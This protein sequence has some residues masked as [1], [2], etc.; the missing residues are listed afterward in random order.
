[1]TTPLL[2]VRDLHKHF[3]VGT[4]GLL[5]RPAQMLRAVDGVSFDVHRGE[6]L[7]L[8]GESG[9]GKSTCARTVV[10]LYEPT[11]GSV[12]YEGAEIS[13]L[14]R[15]DRAPYRRK[16]QMIF[17][18]PYA[19][20]DPRQTVASILAEPLKIHSPGEAARAPPAR[21][22]AAGR[23]GAEP[24]AR[25]P[26]PPRVLRRP[27]PADRR[28]PGARHG[29]RP[30]H[31]RRAR[32]RARRVDPGP[33]GQPARGAPGALRALLSLHRPRPRGGAAHLRPRR[34]DVP[35]QDRRDRGARRAL[36]EPAAPLHPRAPLRRAAPRSED[37]THA[38][39]HRARG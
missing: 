21:D 24:A 33:G 36:R 1:M 13:G 35:R 16:I 18:D 23:R 2:Q 30:D 22:A 14:S 28:R 15:K 17:Q 31:L 27:A 32:Q 25:P 3:A 11:A 37:R 26:L 34:R 20:L 39:A 10:G 19:S 8:V 29:A 5:G 4:K 38:G 7:G 6:T 9:C 12:T